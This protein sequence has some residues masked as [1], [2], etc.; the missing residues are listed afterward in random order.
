MAIIFDGV[1]LL[2]TLESGVSEVEVKDVYEAWKDWIKLSDNSKYPAAFR[3]DGGAPLTSIINQGSYFFLNNTVGWRMKPPEEDGTIYLVGNLAV[4]DTTL[5]AFLPTDGAFTSAILGLQPITQGVTPQMAS[6]LEINTFQGLVCVDETSA[7]S[8]TGIAA[9]G[10]PIGSRS[11]PVNNWADALLIAVERGLNS[12]NVITDS[13]ITG[14]DFSG[15]YQFRADRLNTMLTINAGAN[16]TG[17]SVTHITLNGE[18]D[19]L[20]HIFDAEVETLTDASGEFSRCDLDSTVAINGDIHV[21]NCYSGVAAEGYPSITNI[22]TNEVIVRDQR[23]SIGVDGMTGGS[24]SIGVYG[25]RLVIE[26][27]NSGG[28]IYVRGDPYEITD[29]SGGAVTLVDQ[30]GSQRL[31]EIWQ[32]LALDVDN[33]LTNKSDGGIGAGGIDIVATP[34]GD[35]IIQTRQ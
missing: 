15:G 5:P 14:G 9:N 16:V 20:N 21:I 12:F 17:C 6:Q 13:V 27:G 24:H 30:T 31:H 34:S 35:D 26:A 32:R 2:I 8:G 29:L 19:G 7:F 25:G 23:G 28:T 11:A 3:P 1:A 33:P 18:L 10:S 22:G 4:E